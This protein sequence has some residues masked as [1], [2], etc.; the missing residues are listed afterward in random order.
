MGSHEHPPMVVTYALPYANGPLHLGHLLGTIQ[1]DIWCRYQKMQQ[2]DCYFICGSDTHGTP[3]MIKAQNLK[4]TPQQLIEEM[5]QS[6]QQDFKHFGIQFDHYHSTHH[7][8]NQQLVEDIYGKLKDAGLIVQRQIEQ[9]YD[10]TANMFLPDRYIKGTC[11]KCFTEDQY[12]DS[13]EHCGATYNPL[14]MLNPISIISGQTP[15]TAKTTHLFFRLKQCQ[16]SLKGWIQQGHLQPQVANKLMEWFDQ[17]LKDWDISRDAPYFGFEIPD[18]PGQYFYVWLDAPVGYLASFKEY[19]QLKQ[20]DFD[21]FWSPDSTAELHHFIGKDI[22]YFHTLFWPAVLEGAGY[23]KPTQVNVHGFVT[24]DGQKMSKSRGTFITAKDY[25]EVLNPDYLRYYFCCKLTTG[26]TDLDLNWDDFQQKVNSDLVGKF[27][28]IASRCAGFIKKLND[29]TLS[30]SLFDNASYETWQHMA[31]ETLSYFESRDLSKACKHIMGL[32]DLINQFIDSNPPWVLAKQPDKT[33][34]V[35]QI[36]TQGI[37]GFI[38]LAV[39]L[40]PIIPDTISRAES[41]LNLKLNTFDVMK[42]PVLDHQIQAFKPLLTRIDPNQMSALRQ[43]TT[44]TG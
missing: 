10:E 39:L 6:H 42:N 18:C 25:L 31:F 40:R 23:R 34:D 4:I 9:A 14:E 24:I 26:V 16:A 35:I 2:R 41:F 29:L 43:S 38:L 13:C 32:A 36:T 22:T 11:P 15:T 1:T 20:L 37:N 3:I 33:H 44:S 7:P 19:C 28:N 27:V 21:S 8:T 5:A 17:D 12:G 30:Q